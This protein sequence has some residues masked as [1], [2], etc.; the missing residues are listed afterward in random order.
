M[1]LLSRLADSVEQ[2]QSDNAKDFTQQCLDQ[3]M[4]P[5]NVLLEGLM[6][7]LNVIGGRFKR[8]ECYIPE[9]LLAAK[10]MHQGLEIL[11]PLLSDADA[12]SLGKVVLGTVEGDVHDIGKNILGM[13]LE[14]SGFEVIDVGV[15]TGADKFIETLQQEKAP[16]LALSALLSTT[17]PALKKTIEALATA[18]MRDTVKV[19]VGGA[20]VTQE[21]ADK[22]GADGYAVDAATAVDVAKSFL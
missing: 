2:G 3:G 9:V 21:Y 11:R 15:N 8:N 6:A 12:Q 20:P 19:M 18:G 16:I 17:M 22:I 10:A 13:M 1:E 14:G 4:E 7:G 5:N